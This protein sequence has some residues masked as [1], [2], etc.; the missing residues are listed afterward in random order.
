MHDMLLCREILIEEFYKFKKGSNGRERISTQ[1]SQNLNSV[2][3]VKFKVN[4]RAV[5]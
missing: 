2:A 4:Q 1:I 3:A 5:R